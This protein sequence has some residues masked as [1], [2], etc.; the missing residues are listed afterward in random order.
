MVNLT[1]EESDMSGHALSQFRIFAAVLMREIGWSFYLPGRKSIE[2]P[3]VETIIAHSRSVCIL[4]KKKETKI[5]E[6]GE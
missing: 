5:S 6:H 1:K 4:L 2:K 3:E